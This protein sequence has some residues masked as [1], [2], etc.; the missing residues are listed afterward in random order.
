MPCLPDM[1]GMFKQGKSEGFDSRDWPSDQTQIG[2]K[3]LIFDP[4]WPRN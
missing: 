4:V 1:S 2:F 3:Q